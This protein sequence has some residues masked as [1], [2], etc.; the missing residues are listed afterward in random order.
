MRIAASILAFALLP[1]VT[2]AQQFDQSWRWVH[3]TT[4][5]GL[6]SNNVFDVVETPDST[7]W[8]VCDAGLAWYDG[9]QW[10]LAQTP[11]PLFPD[12]KSIA[13]DYRGDSILV[14]VSGK[15]WCAVGRQGY[16][17]PPLPASCEAAYLAGDTIVYGQGDSLFFLS[18]APSQ[19]HGICRGTTQG[20][21]E[22]LLRTKGGKVWMK[23][24]KGLFRW[25]NNHWRMIFNLGGFPTAAS[26]HI[27]ENPKGEVIARFE[28]PMKLRGLWEYSSGAP[29]P[30]RLEG[31]SE[32]LQALAIS[33]S[34]TVIVAYQFG[35]VLVHTGTSWE[36]SSILRSACKGLHNLFFR[37]N[38]DLIVCTSEG[39]H[40]FKVSSLRW[41]ILQSGEP[42]RMAVN[43]ILATR[44][45]DIW[46]ATATGI[47]LYSKDGSSKI[48]THIDN[49]PM[50]AITGAGEDQDG[51]I[52]IS[53]GGSFDGAY[54]WNGTS[55]K[56]FQISE[57]K[58]GARIHKIRVDRS[59]R[60]WFLGLSKFGESPA[61]R[62]PGVFIYEHHHFVDWGREHRLPNSRVYAFDEDGDGGLWF[63]TNAGI[64]RWKNGTWRTW[65]MKEGLNNSHV[66]TLA[67]DHHKNVWFGHQYGIGL[68]CMDSCGTVRYYT[69][70]DGL[71]N[72]MVWELR[73]DSAG[74]L[75]IATRGG[76]ASYADGVWSRFD[77]STGLQSELLWPVLPISGEVFV[78]T[79]GKGVAVLN[80]KEAFAPAPRIVINRPNIDGQDVHLDWR[81]YSYWGVI[82]PTDIITEYSID[83]GPWSNWSKVHEFDIRDAR[84]GK[85][86]LYVQTRA[87]FGDNSEGLQQFIFTIP[88]PLFM[89]PV[90]L[91]PTIAL[92]V[93]LLAL[94]SVLFARKRRYN[95][96]IRQREAMFRAVTHMTHS[97]IF[98]YKDDLS[99]I[100][101]NMGMERL[102]RYSQA[103][104]ETMKA[105]DLFSPEY[106]STFV[107]MN[108]APVRDVED[109]R[110]TELEIRQKDGERRWV[111]LTWGPILLHD[112]EATIATA[113]DITERKKADQRIRALA[114][115]LSLTEQ[116]SRRRMA[117]FLHDQI[118]HALALSKMKV[119]ELLETKGTMPVRQSAEELRTL[120]HEA[121][122]S[123]RSFT[124]E[125]S[126]PILYDL[127]LVPAID[128]LVDELRKQEKI[129][130]TL[131]K[132]LAKLS[133]TD[134]TRNVLFEGTREL[135]INARKHSGAKSID[136]AITVDG[137]IITIVVRDDGVG[138][139]TSKMYQIQAE[140]RGFGLS[141]LR[142]RL[143]DIGGKMEIDS[144]PGCGTTI[145]LIAPS[146]A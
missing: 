142:G 39:I 55:W 103:E 85:H 126:P 95:T 33:P 50:V 131:R 111:D 100:F 68:G 70:S 62:E 19:R 77:A 128:W 78:G 64:L 82:T 32:G 17:F 65:T 52:W 94:A 23:T 16:S 20:K 47:V 7:L 132:P 96:E 135:L 71:V 136:V 61:V 102:T 6:P 58:D 139:D 41:R 116:R 84:P 117:A 87:Q 133:L 29:T 91:F 44:S 54:R 9:F 130:V 110:H 121:I 67:V 90:V 3:F 137:S 51:N 122:Q 146:Q 89:R 79:D 88:P 18:Y 127:G 69:T 46:T 138:F 119:E 12:G 42:E 104:L 26:Y 4:E 98:I 81:T 28:L 27:A 37:R 92:G 5:S 22:C 10:H 109:P 106:Q 53:S 43:E 120:I 21:I 105:P 101:S 49:V 112:V 72:D 14:P 59:G 74:I 144:R 93:G 24:S 45:G 30:H 124:F 56:H 118:G 113:F 134:D 1:L 31:R 83:N 97:A 145:R 73:V 66:F 25:E 2:P 99:I 57:N 60:L 40:Y 86:K 38:G 141:N 115:D 125:L 48:I 76:L 13:C 36:N 11:P 15:R 34:H 108:S 8:A 63:G 114:S 107:T 75:W 123:S 129:S 143:K 140:N 35:D 80:R